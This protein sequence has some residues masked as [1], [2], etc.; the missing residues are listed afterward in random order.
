ME[1]E[2]L[3]KQ[4]NELTERG[5]PVEETMP[6][7]ELIVKNNMGLVISIAK[8][9]IH[10]GEPLEDLVQAGYIGLLN[11]A[12]N[13]DLNR[14]AKFSTY[15]TFLI[16]GE[17]RHY[18]RDKHTT[19]RVPQWLQ[20]LNNDIKQAEERFFKEYGRLPGISDLANDLNI[21]EDGIREALKAR[22]SVN[23]IS[24][25]AERREGDPRPR[26][27]DVTKIRSK[28]DEDFPIE[29]RI[30]IASAIEKLSD[31]QQ[32]VIHDIFYSGK[33]QAQIGA[34]VGVSQ[35]QIS[36]IKQDVLETIKQD[37]ME[38]INPN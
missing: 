21:E 11:A 1:T 15:A 33:P 18:I 35:R 20:K 26:E 30:K 9:F 31:L 37:L 10:S 34:E 29:Y 12:H 17:I 24:I 28:H 16:Q 22:S 4:L 32:K 19:V 25:D 38:E 36:R 23:Y 3:L 6:L 8:K 27:I 13:Y 7:K 14:G 2:Q 5:A